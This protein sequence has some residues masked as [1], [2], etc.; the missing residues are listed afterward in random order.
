M[1]E[2]SFIVFVVTPAGLIFELLTHSCAP[3]WS[4]VGA[5]RFARELFVAV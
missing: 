5:N 1:R 2:A 4:S 3:V